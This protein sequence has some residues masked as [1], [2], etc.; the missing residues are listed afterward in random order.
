MATD[1]STTIA[2][3]YAKAAFEF[4]LEKGQLQQWSDLLSILSDISSDLDVQDLVQKPGVSREKLASLFI[5]IAGDRIDQNGKNFVD[6]LANNK[7]LLA[8]TEIKQ[9]FDEFK[10][11]Q[12]KSLDV[13]VISFSAMTDSQK[14]LLAQSLKKRLNRDITIDETIDESI[15]GGAIIRAGDLVLDGSVKGKLDKLKNEIAA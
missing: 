10:A 1:T 7:R 8:L 9:T 15:L 14:E 11:E 2:R 12:E 6:M 5:N 4:A 3:P 13:S